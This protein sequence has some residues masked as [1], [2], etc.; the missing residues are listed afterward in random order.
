MKKKT[1]YLEEKPSGFKMP[2]ECFVEP[3]TFIIQEKY[4]KDVIELNSCFKFLRAGPR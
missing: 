2:K 1:S 3:G 4:F